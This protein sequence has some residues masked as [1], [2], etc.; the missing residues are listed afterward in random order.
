MLHRLLLISFLLALFGAST[1]CSKP[2]APEYKTYKNVSIEKLASKQTRLSFDLVYYNPNRFAVK[3]KQT[4][5][6]IYIDGNFLGHSSIPQ[7][8]DIPR[9]ADF[10]VPVVLM[11]DMDQLFRNSFS[12][13]T[14]KEVTLKA[15]GKTRIGKSGI[16][17]NMPV[18]YEGKQKLSLF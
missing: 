11:V 18:Y 8:I 9:S 3:M 13:L 1:S 14:G 15:T 2:V 7:V 5:V 17:F 6:D 4:E 10:I 16:Y 12:A